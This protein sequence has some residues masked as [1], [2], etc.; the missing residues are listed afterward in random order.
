MRAEIPKRQ[1]L[2]RTAST[3]TLALPWF[4][5]EL[6]L[7]SSWARAQFIS[8]AA[9]I[10]SRGLELVARLAEQAITTPDHQALWLLPLSWP[11]NFST[12][13]KARP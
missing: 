9:E 8:L 2:L 5:L 3:A 11:S 10:C 4:E 13:L 7:D 1:Q 6:E 12:D